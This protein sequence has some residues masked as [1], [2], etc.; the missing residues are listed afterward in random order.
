MPIEVFHKQYSKELKNYLNN[1]FKG[2][3]VVI[4]LQSVKKTREINSNKPTEKSPEIDLESSG[5]KL[6]RMNTVMRL[7]YQIHNLSR[8]L[9]EQIEKTNFKAA[10][11]YKEKDQEQEKRSKVKEFFTRLFNPFTGMNFS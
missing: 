9:Q 4:A 5:M 2:S 3:Y 1:H 10:L 8:I 7:S 11:T 6:L